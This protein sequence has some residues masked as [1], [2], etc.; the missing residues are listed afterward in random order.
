MLGDHYQRDRLLLQ[1]YLRQLLGHPVLGKS[2]RLHAFLTKKEAPGRWG[3]GS[4]FF[5]LNVLFYFKNQKVR[6]L[7]EG[8]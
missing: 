5:F 1:E 7:Q 3:D 2:P 8:E 4:V 6:R